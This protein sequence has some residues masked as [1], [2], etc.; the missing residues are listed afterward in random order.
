MYFNRYAPRIINL[1][2]QVQDIDYCYYQKDKRISYILIQFFNLLKKMLNEINN[3]RKDKDFQLNLVRLIKR[4]LLLFFYNLEFL[5]VNENTLEVQH[6]AI[7][8]NAFYEVGTKFHEFMMFFKEEYGVKNRMLKNFFNKIYFT[9]LFDKI[10]ENFEIYV[11]TLFEKEFIKFF[12]KIDNWD[13][14]KVNLLERDVM[15]KVN[16]EIKHFREEYHPY[17]ENYFITTLNRQLIML[18][19]RNH[20]THFSH[21]NFEYKIYKKNVDQ[22]VQT[23]NNYE[24]NDK[25]SKI[26]NAKIL[27]GLENF[28]ESQN[29]DRIEQSLFLLTFIIKKK[30]D[31]NLLYKLIHMK[32]FDDKPFENKMDDYVHKVVRHM[33]LYSGGVKLKN[34]V[35]MYFRILNNIN[36]MANKIWERAQTQ[37][38]IQSDEEEIPGEDPDNPQIKKIYRLVVNND[39][40]SGKKDEEEVPKEMKEINLPCRFFNYKKK[41]PSDYNY[42]RTK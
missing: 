15:K 22:F 17:V 8:L 29:P 26:Q 3:I 21:V 20:Q 24:I 30:E 35:F 5:S 33:K 40:S 19:I 18:I 14:F 9:E 6:I 34:R 1:I 28:F 16:E 11:G 12:D 4:A 10:K 13:F 2:D 38:I 25:L 42:I 39:D 37:G 23:V 41:K 31:L 7:F 36:K 27:K 32:K